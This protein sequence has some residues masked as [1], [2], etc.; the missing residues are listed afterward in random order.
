MIVLQE[1]TF[2]A[3]IEYTNFLFL[4]ETILGFFVQ[5]VRSICRT[6]TLGGRSNISEGQFSEE[7]EAFRPMIE[8]SVF[9]GEKIILQVLSRNSS[10]SVS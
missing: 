7:N 8:Q 9:H 4:A 6:F 1:A 2:W 5:I 10:K 3:I